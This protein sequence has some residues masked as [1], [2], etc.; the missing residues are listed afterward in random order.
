VAESNAGTEAASRVIDVLLLFAEESRWGVTRIARELGVSK[1][2][3]HRIL[4]T[5][6]VKGMLVP[7]PASRGYRLGP[8]AS[9]LGARALHDSDLRAAAIDVIHEL[10]DITG[11]TATLTTIVP[12]G[13]IYLDQVE[14]GQEIKMTV[15]LGRRFPLHAGSSGKSVLAFLPAER[16]EQVLRAGLP[17][18]TSRTITE[19]AVLREEL[20]HIR[21]CGYATSEG[22]RQQDAA[23]VAAPVI[24]HG[25][26]VLGALSVCGPRYRLTTDLLEEIAP[27]V[28]AAARTVS[29]RMG[30][31]ER[32]L[33]E[34]R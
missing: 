12:Q 21:G 27:R 33:E 14:S 2:V 32:E 22:E 3:V 25:G 34:T 23:S 10:R 7:D 28:V 15:E 31:P 6:V 5:L 11:E 20:A 24:G 16:R 17:P 9:V 19:P 1:S 13:R 30:A 4:Q 8:A 26:V 18:V 29:Q